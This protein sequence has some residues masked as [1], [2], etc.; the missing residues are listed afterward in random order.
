M[1]IITYALCKKYV[2]S[3]LTGAGALKGQKGDKGEPFT[4][5]DFTPEQLAALVGP[6]GVQGEVGPKGE[7]GIQGPQGEQGIPGI[8]GEIGPQG[9]Q[10]EIGPQGPKG[11]TGATGPKGDSYVITEN[12]YDAIAAKVAV[13]VTDVRVNGQSIVDPNG[14]ISLDNLDTTLGEEVVCGSGIGGI[15]PGTTF[16]AE[17]TLADILKALLSTAETEYEGLLYYGV[18][19]NNPTSVEGLKSIGVNKNELLTKG[20]TYRVTTNDEIVVLAIPKS[21]GIECYEISVNNFGIGFET[22]ETD[23]YIIYYDYGSSD[24]FRYVYKFEEV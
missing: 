12:D 13:P 20:Y 21:F 7:Q 14:V 18:M 1:D 11:E 16:T 22:Y 17:T 5:D 23:K 10:G 3:S 9:I 4:Y 24:T 8:Q 15:Q 19:K 2:E 6:Q